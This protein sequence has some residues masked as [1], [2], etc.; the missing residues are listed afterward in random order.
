M[1]L[2]GHSNLNPH[3][4]LWPCRCPLPTQ[5][6]QVPFRCQPSEKPR[7]ASSTQGS[8]R[9]VPSQGPRASWPVMGSKAPLASG[10]RG[11]C[12]R[13]LALQEAS[14]QSLPCHPEVT[15][16]AVYRPS[17]PASLKYCF[18]PAVGSETKDFSQDFRKG[19]LPGA[20]NVSN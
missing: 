11:H 8:Q 4:S 12:P 1:I 9:D 16:D 10:G 2:G 19:K 7:G 6:A 18:N 3:M 5:A 13:A 15:T 17:H 14:S 20:Q